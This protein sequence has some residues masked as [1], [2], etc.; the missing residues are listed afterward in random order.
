MP[1]MEQSKMTRFHKNNRV[2]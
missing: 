1:F 2:C